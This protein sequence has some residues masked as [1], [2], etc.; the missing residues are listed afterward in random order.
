MSAWAGPDRVG[1]IWIGEQVR[2][3]GLTGF[4]LDVQVH[5]DHRR[6]GHG[7]AIMV[8]AEDACREL[9]MVA[10]ALNVFG[11]NLTARRLYTNL[12]Y[13]EMSLALRKPI[14]PSAPD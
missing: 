6:R 14:G 7:K 12:G 1:I 4:V 8:A 2:P 5:P 3:D 11:Q 9:G 10:I 13:Q